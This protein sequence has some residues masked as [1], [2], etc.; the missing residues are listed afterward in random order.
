M[1]SFSPPSDY[2]FDR[3][4]RKEC[5]SN[6]KNTVKQLSADVLRCIVEDTSIA[7][8]ERVRELHKAAVAELSNR[9]FGLLPFVITC[10]TAPDRAWKV[11]A[12][13]K[14]NAWQRFVAIYFKATPLKPDP[15][16]F[17]VSSL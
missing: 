17:V 13:D 15:S 2:I 10:P 14:A 1:L 8:Q 16:D 11:Q 7:S 9:N 5:L 12:K 4:L 6:P 3:E